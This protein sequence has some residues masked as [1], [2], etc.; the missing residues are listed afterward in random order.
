MPAK[1]VA[2]LSLSFCGGKPS[3]SFF[4]RHPA[5]QSRVQRQSVVIARATGVRRDPYLTCTAPL[6]P[7]R[8]QITRRRQRKYL[9]TSGIGIF[10]TELVGADF[11]FGLAWLVTPATGGRTNGLAGGCPHP[12]RFRR[13]PREA[14]RYS[15]WPSSQRGRR[16]ARCIQAG[17][18]GERRRGGHK[19]GLPSG[20]FPVFGRSP[21]LE[22]VGV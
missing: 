9:P 17:D 19:L 2:G 3:S 6:S 15:G 5:K 1:T 18:A 14:R 16:P 10:C 21:A 4:N 13:C 7:D 11:G 22:I 20:T 8:L 12:S